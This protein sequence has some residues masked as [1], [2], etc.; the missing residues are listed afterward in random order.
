M[1]WLAW[2]RHRLAL[3]VMVG[4]VIGLGLWMALVIHGFDAA[5]LTRHRFHG[6]YY[7][8]F[9]LG[10]SPFGNGL[11]TLQNQASAIHVLLLVVPCLLGAVLGAP[12]V[13]GELSHHTNRLAWT[14]GISR[15]RWFVITWG[16]V[17]L[18]AVGS[19]TALV[20]LARSWSLHAVGRFALAS[21]MGGFGRTS[22]LYF[23]FTGVVP[24]VYTLFALALATCLGALIRRTAWAVA[25]AAVVYTLMALLMATTVRP[26]LAPQEFVPFSDIGAAQLA[27]TSDQLAWDLGSGYRFAPGS[28]QP[29]NTP[30]AGSIAARCN[31]DSVGFGPCLSAHQVQLG[32]LF[33]PAS[34]YWTLQWR[35]S[36]IYLGL[37]LVLFSVALAAVRRWRS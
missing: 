4:L 30:S 18:V 8:D 9:Q 1:I 15:T 36:A 3:L 27:G 26:L 22:P 17:G 14:Q 34:H 31:P 25:G 33:Q 6:H 19:T 5:L 11:F 35:E 20:P 32:E 37:S 10:I 12:L 13:A 24:V 2:R 16:L 23:A 21:N 7:S 28:V 29:P